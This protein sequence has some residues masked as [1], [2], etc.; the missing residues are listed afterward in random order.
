MNVITENLIL[1]H[2]NFVTVITMMVPLRVLQL[3]G[4]ST[5]QNVF[6]RYRMGYL[7]STDDCIKC[8]HAFL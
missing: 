7:S 1:V 2:F 8:V 4:Y 5:R 6:Y 3:K